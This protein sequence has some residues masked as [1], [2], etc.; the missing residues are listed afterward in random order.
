MLVISLVAVSILSDINTLLMMLLFPIG[1]VFNWLFFVHVAQAYSKSIVGF[2]RKE[3][4][5]SLHYRDE[6]IWQGDLADIRWNSDVLTLLK[7][8][9][10]NNESRYLILFKDSC[11]Q[12][13]LKSLR[14]WLKTGLD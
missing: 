4:S 3:K 13:Q 7:L 6:T 1:L 10:S 14:I 12:S 5:F 9:D 8:V 2:S 11:T